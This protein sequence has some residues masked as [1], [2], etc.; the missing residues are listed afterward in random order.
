[1]SEELKPIQPPVDPDHKNYYV[2]KVAFNRAL[3][4]YKTACLEQEA[5]GNP[6]PPVTEYIGECIHDIAKGY[7]KLYKFRNYSF[8]KDM[9]SD[10]MLTCMKYIRSYDPDRVNDKGEPTSALSYFTQT[11]HYAFLARITSEKK[12]TRVKRAL[13]MSADLDTFSMG[14]DDDSLEFQMNLNEFISSLGSDDAELDAKIV[15]QNKA[16]EILAEPK[17]GPLD[18]FME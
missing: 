1:M 11:C 13:I 14:D 4:E 5:L 18:S 2:D 12:Q 9:E 15:K 7:G 17:I 10:A 16:K 6:A 8:I 3:K